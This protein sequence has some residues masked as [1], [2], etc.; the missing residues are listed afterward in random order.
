MMKF[1]RRQRILDVDYTHLALDEEGDLFLT[2]F[3]VPFVE[4]LLP[5]NF[6]SDKEWFEKNSQRLTGTSSIYRIRT[7]EV[8]GKQR[9]I[10]LKWNRMGQGVPGSEDDEQLANAEF[11]SPFEEFSLL[12]ELRSLLR[13]TGTSLYT[14]KPLAI[15]VPEK[16]VELRRMGRK[17]YLMKAIIEKHIEIDLDMH[18]AYGVIYEW[19]KGIDAT[20]ALQQHIIDEELVESLTLQAHKRMLDC[21]FDVK[22]NKPHHI[23]VRPKGNEEI[24]RDSKN[25][26]LYAVVD[27]ELLKRTPEWEKIVK[28]RKRKEYLEK[29]RDRFR[30]GIPTRLPPPL[31][32][33]NIMGVDYI[34][35][36][37][38]STGGALWVVGKDPDLFDYFLPE[39]WEKTPRNRLSAYN[40]IYHTLT[41]DNINLVWKVSKVGVQPDMDPFKEDEKKILEFGYN[42]PFEEVSLAIGLTRASIPTTYPRAIYMTGIKTEIPNTLSDDSRYE[43]HKKYMTP[44]N[45]PILRKDRDY[46]SIWGYW[47]GPD[48]KLADEDGN[49]YRGVDALRALREGMISNE[50]YLNLLQSI[51]QRLLLAGVEDLNL[52]GSHLL[53]SVLISTGHLITDRGNIPEI[54]ICSFELLK[55]LQKQQIN[56]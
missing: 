47:N 43:S 13:A 23:I 44:D 39:K 28:G 37:C 21:G 40:E 26:P 14:Q 9:D 29:Q 31:K 22:D 15:F 2:D 33:V 16:R 12:M 19:V 54:R 38:E 25:N 53:L 41:K 36:P 35:G 17:E 18:R 46:I 6:W 34:Y 10:V 30:V 32:H 55:D 49:Y 24:L 52:R 11:N 1:A 7:K 42:S 27:H 51:K 4:C 50:T 8:K 5:E 45:R 56:K 48:E 3:A 20:Q